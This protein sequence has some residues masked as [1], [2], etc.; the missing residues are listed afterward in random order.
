MQDVQLKNAKQVCPNATMASNQT[1]TMQHN[2]KDAAV[3]ALQSTRQL[4]N[5]NKA[6]KCSM[7]SK[8]NKPGKLNKS[9][10]KLDAA[11]TSKPDCNKMQAVNVK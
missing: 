9:K 11:R 6:P 3:Q 8:Q 4:N 1:S 5:E 2:S 10:Y 7:L